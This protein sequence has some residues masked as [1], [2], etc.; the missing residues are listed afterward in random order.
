MINR[1]NPLI[2]LTSVTSALL[3]VCCASLAAQAVDAPVKQDAATGIGYSYQMPPDWTVVE[4]KRPAEPAAP[5]ASLVPKKGTACISVSKTAKR[6]DPASV[7]VV[8]E[9]PFN[10]YGQA[11][12]GQDLASFGS[13]VADGLKQTFDI[14]DAV[15]GAYTLGS[16][17][18]WIERAMGNPKGQVEIKPQAKSQAQTPVQYTVEIAC[19]VL[20][21]A[22]VCWM[23]TAADEA[24]LHA[25][26]AMPV[27]LDD[28]AA[29][30]L[31][32]STA[33]DKAPATP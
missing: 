1:W 7:I 32:P 26:E 13:G 19:S 25:F 14:A 16:H 27:V 30:P 17:S 4:T 21:K 5:T 10:C 2:S 33:F 12:T 31:V 6:G 20:K 8:V 9:L 15:L 23:T 11:M 24:S 3:I 29:A 22:A 18:I 28:D